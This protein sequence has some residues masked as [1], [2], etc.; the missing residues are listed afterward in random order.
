MKPNP[1]DYVE[2]QTKK[3][4]IKGILMPQEGKTTVV[5]LD[6]GYNV[7]IEN[8]KIK[9]VKVLKKKKTLKEKQNIKD[10]EEWCQKIE[11]DL[12]RALDF[13]KN[14]EAMSVSEFMTFIKDY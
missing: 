2:V 6:N 7:G 1:G 5:K 3:E 8:R 14:S 13:A 4:V 10:P 12:D 11:Q 9:G